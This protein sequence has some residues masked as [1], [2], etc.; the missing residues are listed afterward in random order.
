MHPHTLSLFALK[1]KK[2]F[3]HFNLHCKYQRF[4][5]FSYVCQFH[6]QL[7]LRYLYITIC[8]GQN[9]FFLKFLP[10]CSGIL[11]SLLRMPFENLTL[12]ENC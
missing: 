8:L 9:F 7:F 10:P 5:V 1:K 6:F 3:L 2:L 4:L 12:P 11:D